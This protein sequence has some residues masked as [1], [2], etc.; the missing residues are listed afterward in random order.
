MKKIVVILMV[1]SAAFCFTS[2]LTSD[3]QSTPQILVSHIYRVHNGVAQ[4]TLEYYKD[5]AY[6]GDTLWAPMM[7]NGVY[8]TLVSFRISADTSA[9]DYY[10]HCDSVYKQLIAEDSKLQE[11]YVHFVEG[12]Y[13]CPVQFIFM[14]K[15]AGSFPVYM[16]L[17]SSANEKYSPKNAQF[18]QIVK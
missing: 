18:I 9:F 13:Y 3:Y 6:V 10:L 4:D 2:C 1:A 15:K 11:G 12:A 5:T 7:L 17:S 8:N 14:P 16:T